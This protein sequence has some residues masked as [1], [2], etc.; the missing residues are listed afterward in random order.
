MV[1]ASGMKRAIPR[2]FSEL[3]RAAAA[4]RDVPNSDRPL[5]NG[6]NA[7]KRERM[8]GFD[9]ADQRGGSGTGDSGSGR[10]AAGL[11]ADPDVIPKNN[12]ATGKMPY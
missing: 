10:N 7:A 1:A 9:S 4:L 11:I 2:P 8:A 3:D 6:S 5:F 12:P